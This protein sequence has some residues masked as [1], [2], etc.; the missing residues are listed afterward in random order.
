MNGRRPDFDHDYAVGAQAEAFVTDILE[1]LRAGSVQIETKNPWTRDTFVEI[2]QLRAGRTDYELSGI[3]TTT[4]QVW[5]WVH[6]DRRAALFVPTERVRDYARAHHHQRI[7]AGTDGSNPT[8]GLWVP[9]IT[10]VT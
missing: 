9:W 10:W 8:R 7:D 2:E 3:A 4:A 6:R 5:A 1:Q